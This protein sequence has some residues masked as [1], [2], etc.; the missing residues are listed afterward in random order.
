M[1]SFMVQRRANFEWIKQVGF[2]PPRV[3]DWTDAA[4]SRI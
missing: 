4:L 2:G 1:M 3:T